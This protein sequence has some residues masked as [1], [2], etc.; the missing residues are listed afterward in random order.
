MGSA[1]FHNFAGRGVTILVCIERTEETE[2][3]HRRARAEEKFIGA[4]MHVQLIQQSEVGC[5]DGA[6]GFGCHTEK[7]Q[8]TGEGL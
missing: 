3:A 5:F 8:G 7:R 2:I 1:C 4:E 6:F